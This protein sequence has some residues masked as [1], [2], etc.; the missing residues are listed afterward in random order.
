MPGKVK[1]DGPPTVEGGPVRP[2]DA[3]RR[4]ARRFLR[5]AHTGNA[6]YLAEDKP[7]S[8]ATA[9]QVRALTAQ[10]DALTRLAVGA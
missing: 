9:E 8:A 5:G 10:V 2:S 6:A 4:E 3:D 1:V 7:T